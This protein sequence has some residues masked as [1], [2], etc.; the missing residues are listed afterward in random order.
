MVKR[1]VEVEIF[2]QRYSLKS[3]F[4]EEQVKKVVAYVDGKMREVAESTKSVDSLHIA[5]LTALNIAQEYLQEKGNKEELLQ[6]IKD[7]TDRLEEFISLK[8]G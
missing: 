7:K 6:R 3:E 5:I 2:G 1:N 8:M 4:P